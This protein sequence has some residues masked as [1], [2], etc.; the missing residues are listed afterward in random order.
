MPWDPDDGARAASRTPMS[1][2]DVPQDVR[3]LLTVRPVRNPSVEWV[4]DEGT[5]QV[6]LIYPKQFTT[7]ERALKK[8]FKAVE[9]VRRPLDGPGSDIWR[10][11]D[12]EHDIRLICDDI[13]L[14][15]KE[16]MEPVLRR[17]VHFIEMLAQRNLVI[18]RRGLDEA[19]EEEDG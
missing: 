13:D 19:E 5:G 4:E 17:V 1:L 6:T 12:G 15:Y 16:R 14:K 18:L 11:C 10:L 9:E 7:T 8:V 2:E 3:R